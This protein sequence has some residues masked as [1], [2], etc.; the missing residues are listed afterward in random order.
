MKQCRK[1]KVDKSLECF[2]KYARS[3]DGLHYYCKECWK[4]INKS[5][6]NREDAVERAV[7]WA[8]ANR[9]RKRQHNKKSAQAHPESRLRARI[10]RQYRIE[11]G[12]MDSDISLDRV[13]AQDEGLCKLCGQS[14]V[15]ADA[16]IDHID[17]LS[18]GGEHVWTN[19]QLAHMT[20]NSRKGMKRPTVT[21]KVVEELNHGS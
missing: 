18:Q 1:C 15:R 7:A 10:K 12:E 13:Y 4:V 17:P 21:S 5:R 11:I 20:C 19:V 2:G 16:S 3:S 6:Y 14:V 8:R 9:K